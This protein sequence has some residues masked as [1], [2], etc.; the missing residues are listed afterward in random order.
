[1]LTTSEPH[2]L[3]RSCA[4]ELTYTCGFCGQLHETELHP[5]ATAHN[6]RAVCDE[7]LPSFSRCDC[8]GQLFRTSDTR[9]TES[10]RYCW[11][12]SSY[13][14]GQSIQS[15]YFKPAPIF[16]DAPDSEPTG[17]YLGVELE[18]DLGDAE[19]AATRIGSMYGRDFL[20]FKHDG[21]LDEELVT[22]DEGKISLALS[23]YTFDLSIG[24]AQ[25]ASS[26]RSRF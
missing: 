17:L 5:P 24:K 23:A 7:C 11:S 1:M 20:Y 4:D 22:D 16:R 13:D 19:A 9:Q 15:Y 25:R 6:G 2:A 3:C 12:C 14:N 10:G 21:S 26:C 18:M 8:C